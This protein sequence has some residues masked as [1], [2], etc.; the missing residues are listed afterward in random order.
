MKKSRSNLP[1]G[2]DM[3]R[4]PQSFAFLFSLSGF[5]TFQLSLNSRKRG[6][7][8]KGLLTNVL[9]FTKLYTPKRASTA[10][11]IFFRC[12]ICLPSSKLIPLTAF[13]SI[14]VF[15]CS[16]KRVASLI[17]PARL[18]ILWITSQKY[19]SGGTICIYTNQKIAPRAVY[20]TLT[21]RTILY[22]WEHPQATDPS[23]NTTVQ[24]SREG[25]ILLSTRISWTTK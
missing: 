14:F 1:R 13:T 9:I 19:E 20:S 3:N 17:S 12:N 16:C 15:L 7:R 5:P 10:S 21:A 8:E 11:E 25:A 22:Q 24:Q 18:T 2:V 4:C 23:R 6:T